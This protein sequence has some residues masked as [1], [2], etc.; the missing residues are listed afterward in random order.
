MLI[1]YSD[2][3]N[4]YTKLT[5]NIPVG[6]SRLWHQFRNYPPTLT[7]NAHTVALNWLR[8]KKPLFL[9]HLHLH[10]IIMCLI[11][12]IS[13]TTHVPH[14]FWHRFLKFMVEQAFVHSAFSHLGLKKS[15]K[16]NKMFSI[17]RS[18]G[19]YSTLHVHTCDM[20]TH[21]HIG[22]HL[23]HKA[24]MWS[25]PVILTHSTWWAAVNHVSLP[26]SWYWTRKVNTCSE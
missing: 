4:T 11:P 6:S 1:K 21:Q 12:I 7:F 26:P 24:A 20:C 5:T 13:I 8:K 25:N 18:T 17:G 16:S 19:R 10:W 23:L 2:R 22:P 9:L 15:N 3:T 14:L